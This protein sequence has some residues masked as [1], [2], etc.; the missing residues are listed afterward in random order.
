M[1][2]V[3][4]SM[5]GLVSH[6]LMSS[7]LS[8]RTC[9]LSFGADVDVDHQLS[10]RIPGYSPR[11]LTSLASCPLYISAVYHNLSCFRLLLQAG[12]N[13][14][15]NS[16]GAV[17]M[18]GFSR[19]APRCVLEAVLRRGCDPHFVQLLIDFGANL[20]LVR[21]ELGALGGSVTV[22]PKAL[23]LFMETK[24]CPRPLSDLCR[25]KVRRSLGKHRLSSTRCLPV[26]ARVLHF[27]QHEEP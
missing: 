26:P 7:S 27:L 2:P 23:Q 4:M 25:I 19:A 20:W 24:C 21:E 10:S 12:A 5:K 18:E 17:S 1:F 3:F 6:R 8:L 15:Y 22:N 11:P 13:P 16:W 14:D 9:F